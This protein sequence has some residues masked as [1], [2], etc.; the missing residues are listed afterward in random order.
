MVSIVCLLLD[1]EPW[2][3]SG[4]VATPGQTERAW[5][6][7]VRYSKMAGHRQW[8]LLYHGKHSVLTAGRRAM[9]TVWL[10]ASLLLCKKWHVT[11]I[12]MMP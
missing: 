5:P 2:P 8:L 10:V 1:G 6:F 7:V 4:Y 3:L 11:H 12:H 9:A